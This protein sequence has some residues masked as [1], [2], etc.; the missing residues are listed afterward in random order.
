MKLQLHLMRLHGGYLLSS[1]VIV[2]KLSVFLSNECNWQSVS[3]SSLQ[4]VLPQLF[5]YTTN[6]TKTAFHTQLCS[7]NNISFQIDSIGVKLSLL[8]VI[9]VFTLIYKTNKTI[10]AFDFQLCGYLTSN[11]AI[12]TKLKVFLLN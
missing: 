7:C 1:C 4:Q 10:T 6:N 11:C 2:T 9:S 8:S 12:V 3:Y 5:M